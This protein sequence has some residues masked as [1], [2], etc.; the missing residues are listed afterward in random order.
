M[1]VVCS[2]AICCFATAGLAGSYDGLYRPT[3]GHSVGWSCQ[4]ADIGMDGGAM[5]VQNGKFFGVENE[6]ALTNPVA[7]RGMQATL[8]DAVCSG[9]G[10]SYTYRLM[11]M[12]TSD[13]IAF[14][15]D[16]FANRLT[17]CD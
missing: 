17:R 10:E 5:A 9:E 7:V 14:V 12:K 4:R 8:Y 11:L 1:R 3:G 16:G 15:K 2:V 13:G 6:C